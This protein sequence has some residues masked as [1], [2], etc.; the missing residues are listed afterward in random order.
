[1]NCLSSDRRV[2]RDELGYYAGD[3]NLYRYCR[4]DPVNHADPSGKSLLIDEDE[5]KIYEQGYNLASD[6]LRDELRDNYGIPPVRLKTGVTGRNVHTYRAVRLM[7]NLGEGYPGLPAA[8]WEQMAR[9]REKE[10]PGPTNLLA[11]WIVPP[12]GFRRRW[13]ADLIDASFDRDFVLTDK[14]KEELALGSLRAPPA[15]VR[16]DNAIRGI[17]SFFKAVVDRALQA[18]QRLARV[19]LSV[20][21]ELAG[22]SLDDLVEAL[23]RLGVFLGRLAAG[24]GGIL[25]SL[26]RSPVQFPKNLLAGTRKGI[27]RFV[28]GFVG[29]A[30]KEVLAWL[31]AGLAQGAELPQ[32]FDLKPLG[33]F[34][35]RLLGL[36]PDNLKAQVEQELHVKLDQVPGAWAWLQKFFGAG[37]PWDGLAK[38][39]AEFNQSREGQSNRLD[40]DGL[41]KEA[42]DAAKAALA[43]EFPKAVAKLAAGIALSGGLKALFNAVLFVV[44]N[45][46]KLKALGEALAGGLQAAGESDEKVARSVLDGLKRALPLVL[47]LFASLI[48]LKPLRDKVA[49]ALRKVAAK[50]DEKVRALARWLAKKLG[51]LPGGKVG[52]GCPL[53]GKTPG[54]AP[55]GK[56]VAAWVG[57]LDGAGA[58]RPGGVPPAPGGRAWT[59][60]PADR[61]GVAEPPP[62]AVEPALWRELRLVLRAGQP[63]EVRVA[64]LRP[65]AWVWEQGAEEGGTILLD[66]PEH[67]AQGE[68]R[69]LGVGPCPPIEAGPGRLITGTFAH[70]QGQVWELRLV[71]SGEVL[72]LTATH[73]VWS[74]DRNAW[75]PAGELRVGERLLDADGSTPEVESFVLRPEPEPV[76]NLEVEGDHCF[77]VGQLG[78]LV[79]NTSTAPATAQAQSGCCCCAD[80]VRVRWWLRW[81]PDSLRGSPDL[82]AA[83]VGTEPRERAAIFNQSRRFGHIFLPDVVLSYHVTNDGCDTDC[84]F[85][86]IEVQS[87]SAPRWPAGTP[88]DLVQAR[89]SSFPKWFAHLK[90]RQ[91]ARQ[92]GSP[93]P[94]GKQFTISD[95]DQP[96]VIVNPGDTGVRDLTITIV[97]R[98]SCPASV[99]PSE[100]R[101]V[102]TQH[103]VWA[104]G[105][106]DLL[107]SHFDPGLP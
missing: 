100:R 18:V 97:V 32:S 38:L 106:P 20:L 89:P 72:G 25:A 54:T 28:A 101:I 7:P 85:E 42:I 74:A 9:E 43:A 22:V 52:V 62:L 44:R 27:D 17:E 8:L 83:G 76:Y 88:L 68:A 98:S 70:R 14:N 26:A 29:F 56:C 10:G 84:T 93:C 31:F 5:Y 16:L 81:L 50:I 65:L 24:V 3:A 39:L 60:R 34:L 71:G 49:E 15:I 80:G 58:L 87:D 53:A 33:M 94:Q 59:L 63:D 12:K 95:A 73:P 19:G 69:V 75:V 36:S 51:R 104:S 82:G 57:W 90:S 107:Y 21:L 48:G 35:L 91:Q 6:L 77:R 30:G 11:L 1:M 78:L 66:L 105:A 67:G 47:G 99:C 96:S 64:L 86:W 13:L 55:K 40:P 79:H 45:P 37:S 92:Q 102:V 103:L 4:N 41:V 46:D 23:E 2:A 61:G